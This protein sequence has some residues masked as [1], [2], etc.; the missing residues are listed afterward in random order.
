MDWS[1]RTARDRRRVTAATAA[2]C[3]PAGPLPSRAMESTAPPLP[4]SVDVVVVGAGQAGLA[5]GYFLHRHNRDASRRGLRTLDAVLLDASARPGGAWPRYWDSLELFSAAEHSSL[6]GR[7]MPRRLDGR[8][9]TAADVADYETR[10]RLPVHR[11]AP[12]SSV[13]LDEHDGPEIEG[14]GFAVTLADGRR[15]RAA[16]VI[17]ATGSFTRPFLPSSAAAAEAA[18]RQLHAAEYRRPE[19]FAGQHV[20]IVGGGNSG[21]QVAADLLP[22]A[23]V[24]WATRRPPR[25]MP[26]DVDGR[27]LFRV[28]TAHVRGESDAAVAQLGEIVAVPSVRRAR[29]EQGLRAVPLSEALAPG[30]RYDAIIWCTGFRPELRHLRALGLRHTDHG[31]PATRR[32]LPT[33]STDVPGLHLLGYGDWCGPASATLIGVG[34]HARRAVQDIVARL[35]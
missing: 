2:P 34:A 14:R 22:H 4:E 26:D 17:S 20:L 30:R 19:P 18:P 31:V 32:D 21:P 24:T 10:Y 16:A 29:D 27:A 5:A 35:A 13:E 11:P 25:F 33:A 8:T 9:P 1:V 12:V 28:A 7:A 6:P 15:V 23:R 3:R